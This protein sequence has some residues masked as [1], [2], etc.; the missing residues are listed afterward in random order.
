MAR[1]LLLVYRWNTKKAVDNF[2]NE[3]PKGIFD[4]DP[5]VEDKLPSCCDSCYEEYPPK[6]E[7]WVAISECKHYLC[8]DCY[9]GYL[10]NE[11]TKGPECAIANC[12]QQQCH[13]I[14]PPELFK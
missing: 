8:R 13:M 3:G 9:K 5:D 14:V 10:S 12:P 6:K 7:N 1:A 2:W 4:F 11:V